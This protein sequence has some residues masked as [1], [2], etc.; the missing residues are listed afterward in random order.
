MSVSTPDDYARSIEETRDALFS[1]LTGGTADAF[2]IALRRQTLAFM[3]EDWQLRKNEILKFY[4]F[5]AQSGLTGPFLWQS[6]TAKR[7][8]AELRKYEP[9]DADVLRKNAEY[10]N[11]VTTQL[12]SLNVK[13]HTLGDCDLNYFIEEV[14]LL[15]QQKT[16]VQLVKNE[17]IRAVQD[18]MADHRYDPQFYRDSATVGMVAV[19]TARQDLVVS[20]WLARNQGSTASTY[21]VPDPSFAAEVLAGG[22]EC[23]PYIGNAIGVVEAVVGRDLFCRKLSDFDRALLL[24]FF[25]VPAANKFIKG[26]RAVYTALR[27]ETLYGRAAWGKLLKLGELFAVHHSPPVGKVLR[28]AAALVKLKKPIPKAL[29]TDAEKALATLVGKAAPTAV[30]PATTAAERSLLEAL[31]KLGTAKPV[32]KELDSF[33]L[34]RVAEASVTKKGPNMAM[35]KGQLLEEF[36]ESRTVKL[37]RDQF[38]PKALGL[39]AA[40]SPKVQFYPGHVISDSSK[41]KLTDGMVARTL[42][43]PEIQPAWYGARSP[44]EIRN[45]Q[46]VLEVLA[47]DEAKSGR[48]SAGDLRYIYELTDAE[49]ASFAAL[50]V[51]RLERAKALAA[52]EGKPFTK[53]LEEFQNE[54]R[55]EFKPGELGG[56]ARVDIERLDQLEDGSLP[57]I[58]IGEL[59]YL[60][61]L[62]SASKTKIFGV[63]PKDV[64]SKGMV[65]RLQKAVKD[66]GEGLN[67]EVI[68]MNITTSE[69][70][71]ITAQA[72]DLASKAK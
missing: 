41:R 13:A 50:A 24:A 46:G 72:L 6:E 48:S 29:L 65:R 36:K 59:E 47:V 71:Q 32:L 40:G 23:L 27:L 49:R 19:L 30:A 58:F 51:R 14:Y 16:L 7:A 33:A 42:E 63:L 61:R 44:D 9:N 21:A 53:T 45:V 34:R 67:F 15:D 70:E 18:Y 39:D 3:E 55:K 8:S 62:K 57:S 10:M 5:K 35:A 31:A 37:L 22:I 1:V 43:G 28:D 66:G 68:G 2:S 26:G 54:I 25:L 52:K 12:N 20:L 64:P 56:Q 17:F 11:A 38:G 4:E 60:V 69:L